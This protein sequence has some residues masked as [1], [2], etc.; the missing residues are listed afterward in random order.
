MQDQEK[1]QAYLADTVAF[2]V[3]QLNFDEAIAVFCAA[4][5]AVIEKYIPYETA[6]AACKGK[7]FIAD[8]VR[9]LVKLGVP[10][11]VA[12]RFAQTY[13]HSLLHIEDTNPSDDATEITE[14]EG[15]GQGVQQTK[16][17]PQSSS[18]GCGKCQ[19]CTCVTTFS[20]SSE[21][22]REDCS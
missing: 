18:K 3:I 11:H 17:T 22:G 5:K 12:T 13:V 21:Q 6:Q 9:A 2:F 20:G 7:V 19:T 16:T 4:R 15:P 1:I 8:C 10:L 14:A